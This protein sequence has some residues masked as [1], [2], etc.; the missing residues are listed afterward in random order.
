MTPQEVAGTG[1]IRKLSA[2][3][4]SRSGAGLEPEGRD[5]DYF[6]A[7]RGW[8][9][10]IDWLQEQFTSLPTHQPLTLWARSANMGNIKEMVI[11]VGFPKAEKGG[12][13]RVAWEGTHWKHGR[14]L[15]VLA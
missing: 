6:V 8:N 13:T 9:S 11:P 12:R 5:I 15:E 1:W 14:R 7:S 2:D 3:V 4:I 10:R